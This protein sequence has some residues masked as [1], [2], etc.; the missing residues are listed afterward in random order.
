METPGC[1]PAWLLSWLLSCM[2]VIPDVVKRTRYDQLSRLRFAVT[3]CVKDVKHIGLFLE[4]QNEI[5]TLQIRIAENETSRRSEEIERLLSLLEELQSLTITD[6]S[7]E[8]LDSI[9]KSIKQV[10]QKKN[11]QELE[12]EL[13]TRKGNPVYVRN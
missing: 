2:A 13:Q 3:P 7:W 6:C 4:L 8:I 5:K 1:Y 11:Q 9:K 10:C 12:L